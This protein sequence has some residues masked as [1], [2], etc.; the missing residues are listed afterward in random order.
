MKNILIYD[1]IFNEENCYENQL[2]SIKPYPMKKL[3]MRTEDI[4]KII[5]DKYRK[6][7]ERELKHF[8]WE[9]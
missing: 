7:D 5:E 9:Y 6:K 1:E 2:N 3:H 4:E 8:D